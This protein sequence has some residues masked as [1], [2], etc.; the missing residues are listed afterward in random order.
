MNHVRLSL[1]AQ[2]TTAHPSERT[3]WGLLGSPVETELV[4]SFSWGVREKPGFGSE[5]PLV[6]LSRSSPGDHHIRI[7]GFLDMFSSLFST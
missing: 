3:D 6:S 7:F 4:G 2:P 1:R 5:H